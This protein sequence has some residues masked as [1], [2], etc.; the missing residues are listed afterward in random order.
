MSDK[1]DSR[2]KE[3]GRTAKTNSKLAMAMAAV[4]DPVEPFDPQRG[5][6]RTRN[7]FI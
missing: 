7:R 4:R 1:S 6:T 3:A 2:M 5:K